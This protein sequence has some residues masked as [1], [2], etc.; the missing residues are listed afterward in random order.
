MYILAILIDAHS[1]YLYRDFRLKVTDIHNK[2]LHN[3]RYSNNKIIILKI[4]IFKDL[5]GNCKSLNFSNR[6]TSLTLFGCVYSI[7]GLKLLC[8]I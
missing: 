2:H 5:S 4:F 3:F 7:I 8:G 6:R 1:M